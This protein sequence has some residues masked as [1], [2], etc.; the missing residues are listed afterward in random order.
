[1]KPETIEGL[2]R[3]QTD[4]YYMN[5]AYLEAMNMGWLFE[6][7]GIDKTLYDEAKSLTDEEI[8]HPKHLQPYTN[9]TLTQ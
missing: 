3:K 5:I 6:L 1:M 9:H 4:Y 2:T 7:D 8:S